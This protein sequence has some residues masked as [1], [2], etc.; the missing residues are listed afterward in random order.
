MTHTIFYKDHRFLIPM[1]F[2]LLLTIV[3]LILSAATADFGF[4]TYWAAMVFV[5]DP[6]NWTPR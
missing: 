4:E 5:M 1:S 2:A 6:K 3:G